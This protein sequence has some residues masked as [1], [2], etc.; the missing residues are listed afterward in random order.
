MTTYYK[1]QKMLLETARLAMG[2][3]TASGTYDEWC[4]H[5]ARVKALTA[6]LN[7]TNSRRV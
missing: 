7:V 3:A 1:K 6:S 5:L 4:G 2:V